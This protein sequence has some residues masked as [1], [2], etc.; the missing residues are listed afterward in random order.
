MTS[1]H[2]TV[3]RLL[4]DRTRHLAAT[5]VL[6]AGVNAAPSLLAGEAD[7]E[8]S[9]A[10]DDGPPMRAEQ[11]A[12]GQSSTLDRMPAPGEAAAEDSAPADA[13]TVAAPPAES[14]P[15]ESPPAESPPAESVPTDSV[16]ATTAADTAV[17]PPADAAEEPAG[18]PPVEV[19]AP[20]VD[21]TEPP[22]ETAAPA[23]A[24]TPS[25][26]ADT[27]AETPTP[28]ARPSLLPLA[29]PLWQDLPRVEQQ[30]LQPFEAQWNSW[31]A[32][33]KRRWQTLAQRMP[34]MTPDQQA[35]AL[36]RI[37]EWAALSPD[38]QRLALRNYRLARQLTADER[39][40]Q[41]ERYTQMTAEE[42]RKL[43]ADGAASN[44]AAGH[45][46]ARTGL[47]KE[48]AQPLAPRPAL[49]EAPR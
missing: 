49:P 25:P 44:T 36:Q 48:A 45:A 9:I 24:Y 28:G 5:L 38:Q 19:A 17:A 30:V 42:K 18:T 27:T 29:Q 12:P 20:S 8:R 3:R 40:A 23:P 47:A 26:P 31:P 13:A 43:R 22:V 4:A 35:R 33:E 6:L 15:A 34:D 39:K 10:P 2:R 21:A 1:R 37:D 7:P 46:G 11:A 41:W 32:T 16:P 14:V